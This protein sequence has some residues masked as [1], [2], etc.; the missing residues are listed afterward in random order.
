MY[1][2]NLSE[3]EFEFLKSMFHE[4]KFDRDRNEIRCMRDLEAWDRYFG[5]NADKSQMIP[6][7]F[8]GMIYAVRE[9]G[10]GK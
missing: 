2:S 3:R 4:E 6:K 7:F 1:W 8:L 9:L 5:P 10:F